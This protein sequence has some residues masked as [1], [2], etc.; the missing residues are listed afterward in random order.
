MTGPLMFPQQAIAAGTG[1]NQFMMT[2]FPEYQEDKVMEDGTTKKVFNY[3][4]F[5]TEK[6]TGIINGTPTFFTEMTQAFKNAFN[7]INP[8][9]ITQE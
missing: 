7:G 5:I 9:N 1:A 3:D 4:K 6:G 2:A 8:A